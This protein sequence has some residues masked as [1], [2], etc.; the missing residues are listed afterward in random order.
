[1]RESILLNLKHE[2]CVSCF[3]REVRRY[4][5]LLHVHLA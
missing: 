3:M 4:V 5:F 1:M 2:F